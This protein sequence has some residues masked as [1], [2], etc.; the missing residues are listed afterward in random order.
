MSEESTERKKR[1]MNAGLSICCQ[2][3]FHFP[4]NCDRQDGGKNCT[5]AAS[6]S[7]PTPDYIEIELEHRVPDGWW[8]GIAFSETPFM[9]DVLKLYVP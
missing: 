3:K 4:V 6:W 9:V 1:S 5:Y 8:T 2:A 7:R